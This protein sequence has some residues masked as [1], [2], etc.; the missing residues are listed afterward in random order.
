VHKISLKRDKYTCFIKNCS[1]KYLNLST[2]KKHFKYFHNDYYEMILKK[3]PNMTFGS[4]IKEIDF[5]PKMF[6]FLDLNMNVLSELKEESL[7]IE[8]NNFEINSKLNKIKILKQEKVADFSY[9]S[10]IKANYLKDDSLN[11]LNNLNNIISL[12]NQRLISTV[13]NSFYLNTSN[14]NIYSNNI[15]N[16]MLLNQSIHPDPSFLAN[17]LFF[18]LYYTNFINENGKNINP[19]NFP[20]N[21]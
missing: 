15:N 11:N 20:S 5:N 21:L 9:I 2:L 12:S 3:F 4:V 1:K 19:Y 10:T 13:N 7:Q 18:D 8:S 14:N 17:R 16:Q 6:K